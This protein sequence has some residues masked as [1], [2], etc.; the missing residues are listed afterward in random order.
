M[1]T[2]YIEFS[3]V[4]GAGKSLLS[5]TIRQYLANKGYK[6]E[7]IAKDVV[8][9]TLKVTTTQALFRRTAKRFDE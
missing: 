8:G 4:T 7:G 9:D 5:R 6:V 2:V 1:P 3:G